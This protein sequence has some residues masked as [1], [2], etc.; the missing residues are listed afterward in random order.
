MAK[1]ASVEFNLASWTTELPVRNDKHLSSYPL[2]VG[3][4]WHGR[5]DAEVS[6]HLG[7][8]DRLVDER[9]VALCQDSLLHLFLV[10]WSELLGLKK[11]F[12]N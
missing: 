4:V 8:D 2:E 3:V 6:S 5:S 9:V 7:L 11:R 10:G 12:E 1:A